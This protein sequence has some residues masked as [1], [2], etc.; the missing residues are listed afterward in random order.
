MAT[1]MLGYSLGTF[2]VVAEAET[3]N[4]H[5]AMRTDSTVF[6]IFSPF[7][8]IFRSRKSSQRGDPCLRETCKTSILPKTGHFFHILSH[9]R[10]MILPFLPRLRP[11]R[12]TKTTIITKKKCILETY[13]RQERH[14]SLKN[15]AHPSPKYTVPHNG[16]P[17]LTVPLEEDRFVFGGR[18]RASCYI[19]PWVMSPHWVPVGEPAP[20]KL[21][22]RVRRPTA[23]RV[24]G[25]LT[26]ARIIRACGGKSRRN[27]MT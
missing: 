1:W 11:I 6:L 24:S 18:E 20:E 2:R 13:L 4:T 12:R 8:I 5:D 23:Q 3:A 22:G 7:P 9:R 16:F 19:W 15:T 27:K 25:G 21:T 26:R 14:Q 10:R 17:G